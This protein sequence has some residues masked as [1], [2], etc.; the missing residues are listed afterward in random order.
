M[1]LSVKMLTD[2]RYRASDDP[3][4]TLDLWLPSSVWGQQPLV[5]AIY[6]H[7]GAWSDPRQDKSEGQ[8]LLSSLASLPSAETGIKIAC[9]SLNYRLSGEGSEVKHPDHVNDIMEALHFL[10][11]NY[12]MEKCILIGHS[13]GATLAVQVFHEFRR[14]ILGMILFNGIYDLVA[15]VDE[16]PEYNSFVAAAFGNLDNR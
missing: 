13:A 2:V 10:K 5:F 8:I 16:Y 9:A 11:R 14:E 6:I 3:L 7:G 4:H 1:F 12:D 15:L